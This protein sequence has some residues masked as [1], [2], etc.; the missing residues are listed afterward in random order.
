MGARDGVMVRGRGI[1]PSLPSRRES[2]Y[3]K[4]IISLPYLV[5][6]R[7]GGRG[8]GRGKGKGRGRGRGRVGLGVGVG[9]KVGVGVHRLAVPLALVAR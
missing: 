2:A 6:G 3:E 8:G 1:V 7:G 9:R 4:A 5:R